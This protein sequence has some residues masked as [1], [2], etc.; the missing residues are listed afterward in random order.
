M[1][2]IVVSGGLAVL[3]SGADIPNYPH[4]EPTIQIS[5]VMI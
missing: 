1:F 3:P 4:I 5:E 2:D